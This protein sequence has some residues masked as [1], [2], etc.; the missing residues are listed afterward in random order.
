M[1]DLANGSLERMSRGGDKAASPSGSSPAQAAVS[2]PHV[3]SAQ[4][5]FQEITKMVPQLVLVCPVMI[6]PDAF[7]KMTM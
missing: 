6:S 7:A 5:R 3:V 4:M 2:S 1:R